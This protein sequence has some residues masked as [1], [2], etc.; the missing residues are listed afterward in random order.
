MKAIRNSIS[1]FDKSNFRKSFFSEIKIK[2]TYNYLKDNSKVEVCANEGDSL[3]EVAHKFNINIEGACDSSLACSTC[4]IILKNDLFE[5]IKKPDE[6]ELDLLD[7]VFSSKVTSRLGCQVK[8]SKE[9][10]GTEISIPATTVNL[11]SNK[12]AKKD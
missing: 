6:E 12:S 2:C 5:K 10:E 7:L 1:K 3:L 11:D 4:H 9:F 8:V